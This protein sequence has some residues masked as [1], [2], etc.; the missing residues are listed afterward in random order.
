MNREKFAEAFELAREAQ[1]AGLVVTLMS[2]QRGG[3]AGDPTEFVI[4]LYQPDGKLWAEGSGETGD[5]VRDH[6]TGYLDRAGVEIGEEYGVQHHDGAIHGPCQRPPQVVSPNTKV[7][8]RE[9]RRYP[10]GSQWVGVWEPETIWSGK[11]SDI[12]AAEV[13]AL[14]PANPWCRA[15][16]QAQ[17]LEQWIVDRRL[18]HTV[19]EAR[20]VID[21]LVY[22]R[23]LHRRGGTHGRIYPVRYEDEED[24]SAS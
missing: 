5:A 24:D 8:R 16:I 17:V 19:D 15:G 23:R 4:A 6:I 14:V 21:A 18:V 7:F 13:I 9:V 11:V 20:E 2:P 1:A 3:P 10:D 22:E 12:L